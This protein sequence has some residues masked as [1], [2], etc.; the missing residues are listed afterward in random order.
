[1]LKRIGKKVI[2]NAILIVGCAT[3][4]LLTL[5]LV[6]SIPMEPMREHMLQS[7]PML[8]REFDDSLVVVGYPGSLTGNFTDCLM[9][10]HAIYENEEHSK[11]EQVLYMYRSESYVGD[12]WAPGNSL[13]DY[14]EHVP[15][16]REVSYSRYWHG[17]LVVLK[18][19]LWLTS[20]NSIRVL[21]SALQ[22][23]LVGMV[24]MACQKRG[25]IFLGKAFLVS[26]PF[27]YFFSMYYSLSL[28]VCFY[29]MVGLLLVQLKYHDRLEEKER[30]GEFFLIAGM[31]TS[32]LDFLTYPLVTLGFPLCVYLYLCREDWKQSLKKLIFASV[33]WSVGYLGFW[34]MKWV[35]ADLLVGAGTIRDAVM[36]LGVRTSSAANCSPL[37]GFI[38]VL[39]LNLSVYENWAYLLVLTGTALWLMCCLWKVRKGLANRANLLAGGVLLLV[40]FYPVAWFFVTQNHAEQHWMFTFKIWAITVFAG[41]CAV[42]RLLLESDEEQ[43]K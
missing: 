42:G 14:L 33:E 25:E 30:Y 27:L 15:Q 20:F 41:I 19:L 31:L 43:N 39:R 38:K 4:G 5:L 34:G 37:E 26:V 36:T 7:L 13:R 17:Y 6:H 1:M 29:L 35:L 3:L 9:L 10:H 23:L 11:L 12:G 24:A 18:P 8:E 21:F 16:P 28:S 22:L 2:S 40:A 32:Y